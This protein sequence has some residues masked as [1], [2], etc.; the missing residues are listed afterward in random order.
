MSIHQRIRTA[1]VVEGI[2]LEEMAEWCGRTKS[3][4]SKIENGMQSPAVE[5]LMK[6]KDR[7]GM[8]YEYLIE[9]K[10]ETKMDW[11]C[12]AMMDKVATKRIG[13]LKRAS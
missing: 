10:A 5:D 11:K 3:G 2:T 8:S 12:E 13:K 6:V 4:W 9:G 7:F 1:R